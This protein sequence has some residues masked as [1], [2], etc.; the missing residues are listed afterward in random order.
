MEGKELE[1]LTGVH[2]LDLAADGE[3]KPHVDSVKVLREL[4]SNP[5]TL[6]TGQSVLIRGVWP[7][8]RGEFAPGSILWEWPQYR[9]VA[10]IQGSRLEGVDCRVVSMCTEEPPRKGQ[11]PY[12]DESSSHVT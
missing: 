4:H 12:K 9:G 2:V 8:F 3:I 7:H 11:P 1:T 5:V 6:G 10:S